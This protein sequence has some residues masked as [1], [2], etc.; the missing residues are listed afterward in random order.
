MTL[1]DELKILDD[2]IKANQAQYDLGRE[3]AKI[4]VLSS[5]DLLKKYEYLTGEDLGHRP[6]VLKNTKFEYSP[7]G[8]SLS[9]ALKKIKLKVVPKVIITLITTAFINFT[10]LTKGMM[11]LK[12][13]H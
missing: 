8:M 6:S 4:S 7:L 3:A 10:N 5:K 11:N 12:K 13:C 1:T 2:K 9:K